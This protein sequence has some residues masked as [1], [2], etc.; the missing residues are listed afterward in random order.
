M[1]LTDPSGQQLPP[2]HGLAWIVAR[3]EHSQALAQGQRQPGTG[4]DVTGEIAAGGLSVLE[5]LDE[6]PGIGLRAAQVIVA[7]I[8]LD[9]TRFPTDNH[10]ASWAR[11]SPRTAQSGAKSRSGKTG[12]GNPYLKRVLGEAATAAAKTDSF[13]GER[14]RRLVRRR[15][16]QRALVAVQRSILV[17]VWHLLDDPGARFVDLGS[18]S[19]ERRVN[20]DRRTRD[21]VRQLM[22]L[23]HEVT[24]GPAA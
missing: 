17:V 11:V 6:V 5:R 2:P 15:G 7:E 13:L 21:L 24:L 18:D 16:K 12:K 14:Y 1:A 4:L 10:L 9:M 19:Y 23:G 20:K 22:A 8:G 3:L